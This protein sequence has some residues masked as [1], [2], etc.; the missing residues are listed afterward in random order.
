MPMGQSCPEE[1]LISATKGLS[2]SQCLVLRSNQHTDVAGDNW[3]ALVL[4]DEHTLFGAAL[5]TSDL[6]VELG[7]L[8][9]TER[10]LSVPMQAELADAVTVTVISQHCDRSPG[11]D[12]DLYSSCDKNPCGKDHCGVLLQGCWQ[13]PRWS[14]ATLALES[15]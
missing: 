6:I 12:E 8:Q 14:S 7:Y 1:S 3:S 11:C 10:V 13:N 9:N 5:M 4:S 2:G 15:L